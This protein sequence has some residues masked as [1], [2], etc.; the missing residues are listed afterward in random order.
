MSAYPSGVTITPDP[1]PRADFPMTAMTAG[2]TFSMTAIRSCSAWRIVG[3]T[4][5]PKAEVTAEPE[6]DSARTAQRS[7]ALIRGYPFT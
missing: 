7:I 6:N 3:G 2:E 4:P 5:A 1:P